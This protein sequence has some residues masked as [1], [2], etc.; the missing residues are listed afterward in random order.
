[1]RIAYLT[2][3]V[4]NEALARQLAE[5]NR[6]M[7]YPL[8][9]RN[10]QPYGLLEAMVYDLD[11]LPDDLGQL[12]L[13]E[14]LAGPTLRVVGVHSYNLVDAQAGALRQRGVVV[15]RCMDAE[16]FQ[17]LRRAAGCDHAQTHPQPCDEQAEKSR[18]GDFLEAH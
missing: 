1:M 17:A 9:P 10:P 5:Q 6:I 3:D 16:L 8:D 7:L 14:L 11:Y 4:V 12:I 13:N 2:T 18:I 15:C